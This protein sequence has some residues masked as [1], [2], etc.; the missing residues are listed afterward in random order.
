MINFTPILPLG[1]LPTQFTYEVPIGTVMIFAGNPEKAV[2]NCSPPMK[3]SDFGWLVCDGTKLKI[4][5]YLELFNVIERM[6]DLSYEENAFYI[7]DYRG[8]FLRGLATNCSVDKGFDERKDYKN[9]DKTGKGIGSVQ[10]CMV[11]KH[12]HAYVDY[13]A[14]KTLPGKSGKIGSP[15]KNDTFTKELYTDETGKK[16]LSGTESRPVNIYV[17]FIIKAKYSM[18]IPTSL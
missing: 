18:I 8:Y 13:P 11:Q 14:G 4:H 9:H 12:E 17:N 5:E 2:L 3:L 15:D 6:Y 10:E 7:P 1:T 16:K